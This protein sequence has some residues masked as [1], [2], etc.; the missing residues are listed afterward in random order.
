[1]ASRKIETLIVETLAALEIERMIAEAIA[2]AT[3][4]AAIAEC[5]ALTDFDCERSYVG[6]I[7]A[8]SDI[9]LAA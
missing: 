2:E 6:P 3:I 4:G 5:L 1:M 7:V 8:C 9:A